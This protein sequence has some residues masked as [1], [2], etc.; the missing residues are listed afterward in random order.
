MPFS[1]FVFEELRF[2][3]ELLA[4]TL[5]FMVPFAQKK[6]NFFPKIIIGYITFS[7]V[8]LL[9]FPI[10]GI[11]KYNPRL[12]VLS[13][14]WYFFIALLSPIYSRLC[15]EVSK[16][17]A[18]FLGGLS[19]ALQNVVYSFYHIFIVQE[20]LPWLRS[21][22]FPYFIGAIL[23]SALV[24]FIAY[25]AYKKL[26]N[27]SEGS[28][29]PDNSKNVLTYTL[30]NVLTYILLIFYQVVL[31]MGSS[32]F[33][34]LSWLTGMVSSILIVLV[35]YNAITALVYSS[36][37][38]LMEEMLSNSEH[39]YELSKE[40]I[41]IINRKCHDLKHQLKVLRTVSEEER[42][43]YIA[44]AER[45]IVF[46]QDLIYTHN[47]ALNTIL[48]EK[49]LFCRESN[50]E[51]HCAVD[52]ADF[53]FMRV[54]DLYALLGNAIDNA[55]EYA[56]KQTDENLRSISLKID[57]KMYFIGF[58]IS[59]PL[60]LDDAKIISLQNN[61][62]TT[63]KTD[64][65]FHGY[66]LKSIRYIAEKYHGNVEISTKGNVFTLQIVIPTPIF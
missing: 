59:N 22:L 27:S 23:I 53:S 16:T 43:E 5:V 10:F 56:K 44:E 34:R 63:T 8:A 6:P 13:V 39:Y 31:K 4:A 25:K 35:D 36:K 41:A 28:F 18:I 29:L 48:A 17:D 32:R 7:L 64:K 19:F 55:I 61:N 66:G 47:E 11:D 26:L 40:H 2:P 42:N 1:I 50:I 14:F 30:V 62:F 45:S 15:F 33:D 51:F 9:Y 60:T 12:Q 58:Q 37:T 24:Y 38:K 49:G 52:D 20:L 46:Y 3:M 57:K 54:S 21:M 65:L